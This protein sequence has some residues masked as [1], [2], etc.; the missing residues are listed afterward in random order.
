MYLFIVYPPC[1]CWDEKKKSYS[2]Y[3]P[4]NR[5]ESGW[6]VDAWRQ[7]IR[8]FQAS[9]I[10]LVTLVIM[11]APNGRLVFMHKYKR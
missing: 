4:Y 11:S 5:P 6:T 10:E 3:Y 1:S 2:I 7:R 9:F 8:M